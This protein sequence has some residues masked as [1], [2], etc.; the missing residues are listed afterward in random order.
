[1]QRSW[2]G[3]DPSRLNSH[4]EEWQ[5]DGRIIRI[6]P[7]ANSQSHA[8]AAFGKVV[9]FEDDVLIIHAV[10][11]NEDGVWIAQ[12]INAT[13]RVPLAN[14]EFANSDPSTPPELSPAQINDVVDSIASFT[15]ASS[16]TST[17]TSSGSEPPSKRLKPPRSTGLSIPEIVVELLK[18][19]PYRY[20]APTPPNIN[21][22]LEIFDLRYMG[23]RMFKRM[24]WTT[25]KEDSTLALLLDF[26]RTTPRWTMARFPPRPDMLTF[27]G[28]NSNWLN[29]P[30]GPFAFYVRFTLCIPLQRINIHTQVQVA[31]QLI[32][33]GSEHALQCLSDGLRA[34]AH[35][36]CPRLA[37]PLLIAIEEQKYKFVDLLCSY[38]YLDVAW[39]I[40]SHFADLQKYDGRTTYE[41][42][43]DI[44]ADGL[45]G[46]NVLQ[47]YADEHW[48]QSSTS[49][50]NM[51][52]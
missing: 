10:L 7:D 14:A 30:N 36:F 15:S 25:T 18:L 41:I 35:F 39:Q 27:S 19:H 37:P 44:V 48:S 46:S 22:E 23:V 12:N 17:S 2:H 31:L 5:V 9:A 52:D 6:Q 51:V 28:S 21:L 26:P 4:V 8:Q 34:G 20:N 16:A 47:V 29:D 43:S 3:V 42:L 13:F 24:A 11:E 40:G 32:H 33:D 49:S 1:M 38:T 45:D 50:V